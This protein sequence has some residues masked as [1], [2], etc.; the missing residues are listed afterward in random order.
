MK[1][2]FPKDSD[3]NTIAIRIS[4]KYVFDTN[5]TSLTAKID[6]INELINERI[7]VTDYT[8]KNSFGIVKI[9]D[10]I[11]VN[12]GVISV[13]TAATK[14]ISTSGNATESQ[15]VMGNDTR[16]T[17]ARTPSND[18]NLVHKSGDETITGT[19]T[20]NSLVIPVNPSTTPT[21]DGSIW[22]EQ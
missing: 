7:K 19:K 1:V 13:G 10:N 4:E 16:L 12:D 2:C 20:F 5:G 15:V 21:T 6:A 3:G 17:D 8:T 11:S 9:G 14:D 18:S 22:F